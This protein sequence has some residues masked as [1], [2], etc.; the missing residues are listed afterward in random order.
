[1]TMKICIFMLFTRIPFSTDKDYIVIVLH[2]SGALHVGDHIL[3]IDGASVEHMSVV[4]ASQL[5]KS[6][7]DD[8]IRLEILPVTHL[9]YKASRE[10]LGRPCTC[11]YI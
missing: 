7:P 3:S 2:R 6:G 1:M 9:E 11:N 5:L 8:H 10:K 4:E